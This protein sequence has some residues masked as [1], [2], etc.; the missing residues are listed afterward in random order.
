MSEIVLD[1]ELSEAE[2]VADN[3]SLYLRE[4]HCTPPT[5]T[6]PILHTVPPSRSTTITWIQSHSLSTCHSTRQCSDIPGNEAYYH[7]LL[8]IRLKFVQCRRKYPYNKD[9]A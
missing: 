1:F 3:S 2:S 8:E 7:S 5:T 4:R 9:P 6:T